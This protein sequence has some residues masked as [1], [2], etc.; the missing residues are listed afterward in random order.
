MLEP[1]TDVGD[2]LMAVNENSKGLVSMKRPAKAEDSEA[3]MT[4]PSSP[5]QPEYGW[6]LNLRLE[7]FELEK[8]KLGLPRVGQ[9]VTIQ[10]VGVVTNVHQSERRGDEEVDRGVGIQ[11]TDLAVSTS[12]GKQSQEER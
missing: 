10:A 6:G 5:K 7:N 3:A 11:I 9:K 12:G 8:L 1:R 2:H 4:A